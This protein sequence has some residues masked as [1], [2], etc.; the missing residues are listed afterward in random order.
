M[1]AIFQTTF[2]NAIFLMK[3]YEFW[4]KFHWSLFLRVDW[5]YPGIDSDNVLSPARRQAIIWTNDGLVHWRIY[6]SMS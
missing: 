5:Q 2:T 3:M 6:V 1:A 4:L